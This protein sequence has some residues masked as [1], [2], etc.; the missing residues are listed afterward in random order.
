MSAVAVQWVFEHSP[1]KGAELLVHLAIADTVNE[2]NDYEF[3]ASLQTLADKTRTNRNTVRAS[4][5]KMEDGGLLTVLASERGKSCRYLFNM[6]DP[7]PETRPASDEQTAPECANPAPECANPAPQTRGPR[8]TDAPNR[9]EHKQPKGTELSRGDFEAWWLLYPRKL[10]KPAA[11]KAH[12]KACLRSS[13]AAV[14]E[15]LERW[16]S[17]WAD[18]GTE[19][20]YIP[21]AST[22]LN[23]DQWN[24]PCPAVVRAI[25]RNDRNVAAARTVASALT[26]SFPAL[27]QIGAAR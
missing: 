24:D 13:A 21:H 5:R 4:V 10:A 23:R 22:W 1:L 14:H 19:P 27:P 11:A 16:V 3:W 18:A 15:G 12:D 9:K 7:A 26:A 2:K 20:Q 25:T 6:P 17:H 8:A